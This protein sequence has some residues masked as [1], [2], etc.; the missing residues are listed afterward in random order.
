MANVRKLSEELQKVAC[1][2]L[3]E[4]PDRVESDISH[5]REWIKQHPHLKSRDDDQFILLFLRGCKFSLERTK[6]KIALYYTAR[7]NTPEFFKD[8]DPTDSFTQ[9]IINLGVILPLPADES[10]SDPRIILTR[11]GG[12][13]F[14]KYSLIDVIKVTY[15]Y[16]D[17]AILHSDVTIVSGIVSILDLRGCGMSV[18]TQVTPSLIKKLS[19]LLGPFPVLIKAVHLVHPPRA[20]TAAY[21]MFLNVCHEKLRN[22]VYM[23]D[24]FDDLHKIV[25]KKFLPIE[26]GGTN[27]NLPEIIKNWN[28]FLVDNRQWFLDDVNYGMENQTDNS[29][30]SGNKMFGTEGSFRSL[31]I[32]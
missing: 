4:V 29:S 21:N 16:S 20:I 2:K 7:T 30:T 15:F 27:S 22:R 9:E 23:H 24:S 13:D 11:V 1:E 26:Y 5:I 8:R 31:N 3:N 10:K 18:I 25:D 12:C 19:S 6:K 14:S 28:E 17:M 32:D